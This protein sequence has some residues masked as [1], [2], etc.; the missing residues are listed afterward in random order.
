MAETIKCACPDCGAK[1][2]LPI[3]AQ[4]RRAK[5]KKCGNPFSVPKKNDMEDSILSWL[6]EPEHEEEEIARPRV[7]NMPRAEEAIDD[8]VAKRIRGPIRI[9]SD[10]ATG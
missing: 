7:I 8:D 3:E 1:Y 9:K 5:C 2:R 6:A 10:T 4:G